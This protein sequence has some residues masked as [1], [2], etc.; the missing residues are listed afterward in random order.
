MFAWSDGSR[1]RHPTKMEPIA[2][3]CVPMRYG[4]GSIRGQ[5]QEPLRG[6]WDRK[7]EGKQ[8]IYGFTDFR[9]KPA[10]RGRG[11][12]A[13]LNQVTAGK[14]PKPATAPSRH[15]T[16]HSSSC[17]HWRVHRLTRARS[18]HTRATLASTLRASHS[19]RPMPRAASMVLASFVNE[20]WL[21][22][23]FLYETRS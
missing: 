21:A 12:H 4:Q 2:S 9:G 1:E 16:I 5:P 15:L 7:R 14:Q 18:P 20:C 6:V 23:S 13:P 17:S 19:L 3:P 11:S 8:A 10:R 22:S